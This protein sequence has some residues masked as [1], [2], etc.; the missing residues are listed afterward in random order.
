MIV[1]DE[2]ATI[3]RVLEQA[4]RFC[5][6]LVV[7]DTGSTDRSKQL[8]EDR[9]ARVLDFAWR[10]DFAAAR[11]HSLQ[12]CTGDWI[13][14]LDADDVV[15]PEV[16]DR[17]VAAKDELFTDALDSVY[18]PYRRHFDETTGQ[19]TFSFPRERFVRRVPDLTWTGVVHEVLDVPGTRTVTRDDLYIEH[20]PS[21]MQGE[22]KRGRNIAILEKAY[23]AG[24]R[25]PRTLF[26]FGNELRDDD[27]NQE[28]IAIYDEYLADPG[29][30]WEKYSALLSRARCL[31]RLDRDDDALAT[32]LHAITVDPTRAEAFTAVGRVYYDRRLWA[33][34]VPFYSAAA[35]CRRPPDGFVEDADYTFAALDFLGVCLANS[36]RHE[37]AITA[38][39]QSLERGNPDAERLRKNLHWSID[40]L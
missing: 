29:A 40:Q 3:G 10:D 16:I 13:V 2:E 14:W 37:E 15:A 35:S 19:C 18:T 23:A 1:R 25:A 7:V 12:A 21:R 22:R 38:T 28:A 33:Q 26:Y 9:G 8:A 30:A 32:L 6:E 11:N 39:M 20:R 4:A 17:I 34:A 24:D 31:R 36:D 27:R 5:D